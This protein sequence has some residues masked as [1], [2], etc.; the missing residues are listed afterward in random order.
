MSSRPV[1]SDA[2]GEAVQQLRE[3]AAARKCWT[4]GCLKSSVEGIERAIPAA[5]QPPELS[6]ALGQARERL[7]P[8]KYDCLGC[9]VCYPALAVNALA[10]TLAERGVDLDACPADAVSTRDGWPPLPGAYTVLRY[11]APVAICTLNDEALA[12]TLAGRASEDVA[13]VGTMHTE[14]LGIERLLFN[15]LANPNIRF[16][17]L[18]GADSKQAIGHLPGQSLVALA[19]SGLDERSRIIGARGKRPIL[20]NINREAVGHFRATVEVID[21]IG[22][23]DSDALLELATTCA[24][25]TLGEAPAFSTGRSVARLAGYLPTRMIPDPEG[26]FVVY[27]DRTRR[28]LALEHYGRDGVLHTLIEG[29][30]AAE[31]YIPAV[32]K[33]LLSRLD[34]AAYLGRELARAEAALR[35]GTQYVQDAAPE[36]T[37][38]LDAVSGCGASCAEVA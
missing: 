3:V 18:C 25:K 23:I 13:L 10:G 5:E 35:D 26:Y 7:A 6:A 15:V 27:V 1:D 28:L 37:I 31:L 16:L 9:A 36:R 30:T 11:L 12:Q 8:L 19:A 17:I 38:Q 20:K 32:E 33:G 22:T 24:A 4:C 2:V 21:R 29:H 34:H 14:N